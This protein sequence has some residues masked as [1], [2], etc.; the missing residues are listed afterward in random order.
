MKGGGL[1]GIQWTCQ[2]HN[3]LVQFI[4]TVYHLLFTSI[5][6]S[7]SVFHSGMPPADTTSFR[8]R[9]VFRVGTTEKDNKKLTSA[10]M[11][12]A[13]M[14]DC[15]KGGWHLHRRKNKTSMGEERVEGVE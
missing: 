4:L 3:T 15:H 2:R 9:S 5:R 13:D 1:N 7:F 6:T 11:G 8:R 12:E 10:P 14:V